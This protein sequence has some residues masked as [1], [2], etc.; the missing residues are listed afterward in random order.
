MAA[1]SPPVDPTREGMRC[2]CWGVQQGAFAALLG[3]WVALLSLLALLCGRTRPPES[4]SSS[5][6]GI[7]PAQ[8]SE[9]SGDQGRQMGAGGDDLAVAARSRSERV[10]GFL[11][12]R[13]E[14]RREWVETHATLR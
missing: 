10:V 11:R 1:S 9:N 6:G 14:A 13:D 3:A 2:G 5:A 12:K 7:P 8:R 4:P